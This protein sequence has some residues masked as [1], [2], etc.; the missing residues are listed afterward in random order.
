MGPLSKRKSLNVTPKFKDGAPK[1]SKQ[2]PG[3]PPTGLSSGLPEWYD[4]TAQY[5]KTIPKKIADLL[6]LAKA[7][8]N[9]HPGSLMIARY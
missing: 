8:R 6:L 2:K 1:H 5:P 7:A 3:H 9:S 4:R